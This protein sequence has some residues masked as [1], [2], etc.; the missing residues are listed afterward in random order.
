MKK[1]ILTISI[2]FIGFMAYCQDLKTQE[3]ME[4]DVA[5][6]APVTVG[7]RTL[8]SWNEGHVNG[9]IKGKMLPIGAEFGKE[10]D[11]NTYQ[12]DVRAVI[13]TDDKE[14][15]YMT[16][17]GYVYADTETYNL[18]NSGHGAE[19][20]PSK[21]YFRSNPIFETKSKKYAWLN[22]TVSV[23]VGTCTKT[24]VSYKVYAIK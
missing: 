10:I 8:Y 5:L 11:K 12:I 22:H 24:G 15:I 3:I 19:V 18:I 7:P 1:T 23:G 17:L 4:F 20:D 6:N 13:E 2:L 16:Y 21:Y 9:I 14:T